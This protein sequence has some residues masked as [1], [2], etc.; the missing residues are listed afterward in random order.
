MNKRTFSILVF[1]PFCCASAFSSFLGH[2]FLL[3]P[4]LSGQSLDLT[5]VTRD[6]LHAQHATTRFLAEAKRRRLRLYH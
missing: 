6:A 1:L 2:G 3:S 5:V 4:N